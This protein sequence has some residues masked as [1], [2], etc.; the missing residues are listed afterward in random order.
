MS[1]NQQIA[2]NIEAI[3]DELDIEYTS[4]GSQL[5]FACPIHGGKGKNAS[6]YITDDYEPN[7]KCWSYNCHS[8]HSS[9]TSFCMKV[10][11]TD[12]K[13]L[14][15]WLNKF[16]IKD[17]P[18][19]GS[20]K[21]FVS[22]TNILTQKRKVI[23]DVITTSKLPIVK[24][25]D[26]YIKR[27][28]SKDILK[29]FKVGLCYDRQNYF[30]NHVVVPIFHDDGKNVAGIIARN[31]NPKCLICSKH[32]AENKPCSFGGEKWRNS[33]GFHNNSFLYNF[34]NAKEIIREK[35][36]IILVEGSADV[37]KLYEAGI[38]NVVS[39][40][41]TSLSIDQKLI[42]ESL[43]LIKVSIF[44]DPDE[45]GKEASLVLEK[46]LQRFYTVDII[47]NDKQPSDCTTEELRKLVIK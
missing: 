29:E 7:W 33:K 34:W 17:Q 12:Y 31:P 8:E 28:I 35:Q 26:F 27:G 39:M 13:G 14:L 40:F 47:Q 46:Y 43:P 38:Y 18:N 36:H 10:L 20:H 30:Y 41:G 37:W 6:I 25:A 16:D 21:K 15:E 19:S 32:H 23:K 1:L 4:Q 9:L 42:L 2:S 44:L 24:D 45:A 11:D 3:L 5:R 22:S